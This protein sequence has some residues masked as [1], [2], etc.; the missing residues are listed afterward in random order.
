MSEDVGLESLLRHIKEQRGFDFTGYKRASLARRVQRRM[1]AVGIESYEEYLDYL[2]MHP[3]EFTQLFNTILINVTGFFRDIEAWDYLREDL[4]APMIQRS[5]GRPIRVWSAG[6]ASGEEAYTLAMTFAELLGVDEFRDRVKIYATDLDEEALVHGR[7]ASYSERDVGSVPAEL[8]KKYFDA[9]GDR[10]VFRKELRRSVIFGRNDLVQDAPISHVDVLACRNTLMYFNAETQA[11]ILSRLHFALRPE[12]V[13]FL[14]KAEM[15]LSHSADFRAVE[16][17]RRF[18]KK[19]ASEPR[20]RRL[21]P[22]AGTI[23][24]DRDEGSARSRL[25]HAALLSSAAAQL[26]LDGEGRLTLSNH[27]AMHLFG[28]SNRDVGRPIQDLEISYRPLEL[29]GHIEEAVRRRGPVWVRE[30]E[31]LRGGSESMLLDVQFVPLSD[32]SGSAVGITIIFHDVTQHRRLER[33]LQFANRQL[34]TAYEELQSTNEEL[35]TT[36][37]ELQSTVEEL[38]TT[39]EELQSTNEELETMNEELQSMNDELQITNESLRDRQDEV[40]RLNQFMGSVL[41]SMDSGVAVVDAD[42]RLLAWNARAED[43]WGIRADEAFNEHLMNLDI[44]LPVELLRQPIRA[45]LADSRLEPQALVLDAVNRRG[46]KIQ[47]RVTLTHI[48]DRSESMPAAMLAME[49]VEGDGTRQEPDHSSGP[50]GSG[51]SSTDPAAAH[52]QPDLA[53]Q[54]RPRRG[55]PGR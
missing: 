26:V 19:I 8:R 35:E 53:A 49:V 22:G 1:G 51:R 3:E 25:R 16:L 30:I 21:G 23:G 38:E 6:C 42:M 31:F 10:F 5:N 44:G 40:D 15:L 33:E 41:S 32:E 7:Q 50:I 28:L 46:R 29:R 39:N 48:R 2:V 20:D 52:A 14:G 11:Q 9:V 45:Q 36:N 27:R 43:L 4:L 18:F 34:E 12:G 47:V 13:L 24:T 17:K 55:L 54:T 37:E